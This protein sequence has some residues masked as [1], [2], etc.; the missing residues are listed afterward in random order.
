M[1]VVWQ[2]QVISIYNVPISLSLDVK[3]KQKEK[4]SELPGIKKITY[5]DFSFSHMFS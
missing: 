3:Y 2:C 5:I 1:R 4:K